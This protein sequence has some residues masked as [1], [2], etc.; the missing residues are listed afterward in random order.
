MSHTRFFRFLFCL[1]NCKSYPTAYIGDKHGNTYPLPQFHLGTYYNLILKSNSFTCE[2]CRQTTYFRR[3]F[4]YQSGVNVNNTT[5]YIYDTLLVYRRWGL[6]KRV[7]KKK[8]IE[9][10]CDH[11]S[12]ALN[13]HPFK[14]LRAPTTMPTK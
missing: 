11:P 10:V 4:L 2:K 8:W 5:T 7:I 3:C 13:M 9:N 6:Y 12:V 14:L 1:L